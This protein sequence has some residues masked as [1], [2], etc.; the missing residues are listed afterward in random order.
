MPG[1]APWLVWTRLTLSQPPPLPPGHSKNTTEQCH[2]RARKVSQ[3]RGLE[4]SFHLRGL[5]STSSSSA[6]SQE[7]LIAQILT[8]IQPK[9]TSA[10]QSAI[11]A[12]A[13][14]N[15]RSFETFLKNKD[16]NSQDGRSSSSSSRSRGCSQANCSK[17]DCPQVANSENEREDFFFEQSEFKIVTRPRPGVI[18]PSRRVATSTS[19]SGLSDVFGNGETSVKFATPQFQF[20]F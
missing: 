18:A 17:A 14:N 13:Q 9:I 2:R 16:E 20:E 6:A 3:Q 1:Q 8:S 10:V 15:R 12:P 7:A 5:S 4:H 11:S 19:N